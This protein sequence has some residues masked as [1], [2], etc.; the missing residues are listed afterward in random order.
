MS[1]DIELE[2]SF[3]NN[4][5][6]WIFLQSHVASP[7]LSSQQKFGMA[8]QQ[9]PSILAAPPQTYGVKP[10]YYNARPNKSAFDGVPLPTQQNC[11][12]TGSQAPRTMQVELFLVCLYIHACIFVC[13][14]NFREAISILDTK[15][16]TTKGCQFTS[17]PNTEPEVWLRNSLWLSPIVY[18][19]CRFALF[20][21]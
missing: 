14:A 8:S 12:T 16:S 5:I 1:L 13:F 4:N 9:R 19:H 2:L 11:R 3:C 6:P 20:F 15:S 7:V 18:F 21:Q 10:Q 17:L